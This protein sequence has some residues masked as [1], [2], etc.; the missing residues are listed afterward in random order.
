[1]YG[2]GMNAVGVDAMD[3][4]FGREDG[5][6]QWDNDGNDAERARERDLTRRGLATSLL[7]NDPYVA[8]PGTTK[9]DSRGHHNSKHVHENGLDSEPFEP[10]FD[11][12]AKIA[13]GDAPLKKKRKPIAPMPKLD[14]DVYV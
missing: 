11:P 7:D 2:M 1:M 9:L 5:T 12:L 4:A 13:D 6:M 10:L 8:I 3:I 14:A